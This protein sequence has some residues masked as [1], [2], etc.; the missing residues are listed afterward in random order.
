MRVNRLMKMH[1][2]IAFIL[3]VFIV[4][5]KGKK[6]I[7]DVS[8]ISV[9]I[10]TLR[11]EQAFFSIDTNHINE[12][13]Q[14]LYEKYPGFTQDF[15]FNIVGINPQS[16]DAEA[17]IKRFISTYYPIYTFSQQ[18]FA[19]LN[20][21]DAELK[22]GLQRVKYYFPNY[23]L[24]NKL[25]TFIGPI[26]SY[27][28]IITRDGLATGLQLY[29]GKDYPLYT[30]QEAQE[31]YPAYLS[32]RFE[33]NYI[34]INCI[35]N[36]IDDIAPMQ[37]GSKTLLE[38]I[39][40]QGKR[41][42]ILDACLPN[43]ADSLKT[44]YTAKQLAACEDN[45]KALWTFFVQNNLLYSTDI[46]LTAPYTTDGPKTEALGDDAPGNIGLFTGWKIVQR[47]MSKQEKVSMDALLQK[48]AK[49]LFQ[50]AKYKP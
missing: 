49:T 30:S 32:R 36:I 35:K 4:G 10:A 8:G 27:G 47:W 33:P 44:G 5:C 40:E 45:E 37:S 41:L 14:K 13:V 46:A 19:N 22:E 31:M 43:V 20:T 38:N 34:P 12:G 11:F 28:N 2:Y 17:Q 50:E 25:I 9:N 24:P 48:D 16:P 3:L 42:Y 21:I 29:L 26:N 39:I 23:T 7:P 18:K 1:K 6:K 15:L